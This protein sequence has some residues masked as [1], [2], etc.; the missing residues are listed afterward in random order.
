LQLEAFGENLTFLKFHTTFLIG[1]TTL[2][3]WFSKQ[4]KKF[5]SLEREQ[6]LEDLTD[7]GNWII[8]KLKM[9]RIVHLDL[10]EIH[11]VQL[12][13]TFSMDGNFHLLLIF[14]RMTDLSNVYEVMKSY[15]IFYNYSSSYK[16]QTSTNYSIEM[17]SSLSAQS[18]DKRVSIT[19]IDQ[20]FLDTFGNLFFI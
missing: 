4:G 5:K 15:E 3:K 6:D 8:F 9:E 7:Y 13:Q 18:I 20:E 2:E 1:L 12:A 14:Q 10:Q 11:N 16:I 17:E 19:M